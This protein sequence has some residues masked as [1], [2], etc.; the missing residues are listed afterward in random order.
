MPNYKHLTAVTGKKHKSYV[1]PAG[2]AAYPW[3]HKPDTKF[4][5]TGVFKTNLILEG[6]PADE[7]CT[8][9]DELVEES[10]EDALKEAKPAKK[11]GLSRA[12]PYEPE[13]D[14]D[15]NETGRTFFKFKQNAIIPGKDGKE[16]RK[17]TIPLFNRGGKLIKAE[18]GGGSEIKVS[19]GTRPYYAAKDNA[20]GIT[21]DLSA[22]MV[23]K[24][25]EYSRGDAGSYGF[26]VDPDYQEE[27]ND[28][29][30][31]LSEDKEANDDNDD[32]AEEDY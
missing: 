28:I 25:V 1:T 5:A 27:D 8:L 18:I 6:E 16:D 24:L 19:F 7:L 9:I 13:V 30:E 23:L 4:N 15:G 21:L 32:S 26:G 31:G 20:A 11:K 2:I 12:L 10:Y 17:V 22:V 14:A 29:N 3:L